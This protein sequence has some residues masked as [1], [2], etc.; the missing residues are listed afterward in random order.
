MIFKN[1]NWNSYKERFSPDFYLRYKQQ[2]FFYTYIRKNASTSFKKL[3]QVLYPNVCP[4]ELPTISCMIKNARVSGLLPEDIDQR[5]SFKIFVYRDPIERVF[6]VYKNKLVQQNGAEDL[7]LNLERVVGRDPGLLTFDEFVHEYVMLLQSERW[8]EVDGHLYPQTWHLLP[9]TYNKVILMDNVYK[10]MQELLPIELCDQVF[11]EPTNS[12]TNGSFPL[13]WS[14]PECPA[15]YFRKKYAQDNALPTLSQLLTPATE[16]S[17]REVY[18]EDYQMISE[19]E[20]KSTVASF[21]SDLNFD[22]SKFTM[23][24]SSERALGLDFTLPETPG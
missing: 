9:I 4:G 16:A 12:T 23:N 8:E 14:D 2:G 21:T 24:E 3:F 6:S 17:I 5:F 22:I 18:V 10:E 7:L 1:N 13:L 11:K 19:I 15:V 20:G